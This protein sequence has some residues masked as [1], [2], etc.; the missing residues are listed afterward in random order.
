[1]EVVVGAAEARGGDD[2]VEAEGFFDGGGCVGEVVEGVVGRGGGGGG[3]G[4][5]D[6]GVFGA[7]AG[8]G[9]GVRGEGVEGVG[10]GCGGCVVPAEEE[11]EHVALRGF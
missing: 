2:G 4:A 7:E 11:E 5:E 9:V 10:E 6:E 8:E 3:G 1:M